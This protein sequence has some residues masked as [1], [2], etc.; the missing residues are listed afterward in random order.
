MDASEAYL[1]LHIPKTAGTSV[2]NILR[3]I[4]GV[5]NVSPA[6]GAYFDHIDIEQISKYRMV[7][8]HFSSDQIACFPGRKILTF[9]RDPVDQFIS[10]YYFYRSLVESGDILVTLCKRYSL[11][12]LIDLNGFES[13][14]FWNSYVR[15]LASVGAHV[16]VPDSDALKRASQTLANCEF[17]G[18]YE[19]LMD[20]LDVMSYTFGWP[21]I[22]ELPRNNVINRRKSVM[23]LDPAIVERIRKANELDIEL[24]KYA[25]ELFLN[26]KRSMMRSAINRR[27]HERCTESSTLLA[28]RH[29]TPQFQSESIDRELVSAE[30]Q[31]AQVRIVGVNVAHCGSEASVVRSG[32]LVTLAVILVSNAAVDSVSVSI[33]IHNRYRQLVFSGSTRRH[34]SNFPVTAG[35][36]YRAVFLMSM[37]LAPGQYSVSAGATSGQLGE[38]HL[39]HYLEDGARFDVE[40]YAQG[41]F[42]GIVDLAPDVSTLADPNFA[43]SYQLGEEVH[44]GLGGESGRFAC[45]GWGTSEDWGRWTVKEEADLLMKLDSRPNS[46]VIMTAAVLAFCPAQRPTLAAEVLVNGSSMAWWHFIEPG[47]LEERR[48]VIPKEMVGDMLHVLFRIRLPRAP[49][50]MGIS[51]DTR[52][53]GIGLVQLRLSSAAGHSS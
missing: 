33:L 5:Q 37:K 19:E 21:P 52:A 14:S 16:A 18:I 48:I 50:D 53:L 43:N 32:D 9:L 26:R 1:F 24:Y 15:Q 31:N 27:T 51:T 29:L 11:E 41:A 46:A 44:F 12:D 6:V 13:K 38:R 42:G 40:G 3:R 17:I 30:H 10:K 34:G 49:A 35:N 8:G 4:L 28:A 47:H 36:V 39:F 7:V 22:D 20:A 25:R 23:E 45:R 2:L